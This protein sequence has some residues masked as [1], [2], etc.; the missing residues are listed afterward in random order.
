[1]RGV[2]IDLPLERTLAA[3]VVAAVTFVAARQRH[4][5]RRKGATCRAVPDGRGHQSRTWNREAVEKCC[6]EVFGH[7][8][9]DDQW[10]VVEAVLSGKDTMVVWATGTGKSLCYQLLAVLEPGNIVIVV[11]PTISLM[12][13]QV[14][15]FNNVMRTRRQPFSAC[16]L[17]P[18]EPFAR[19]VGRA[20]TEGKHCLIYVSPEH[21]TGSDLL[22]ALSDLYKKR[23][24]RLFAVD[25]ADRISDWGSDF[26]VAFRDLWFAREKYSPVPTMALSGAA[27]PVVRKDVADVL[28]LRKP[29]HSIGSFYRPNLFLM[30][31]GKSEAGFDD[32]MDSIHS[33]IERAGGQSIV[34]VP[35]IKRCE[36]VASNLASR[37]LKV[38]IYHGDMDN[39]E[40]TAKQRIFDDNTVQVMV[41]TV[42]FGMG[43]NKPNIRCIFQY[44]APKTVEDYVQQ[45]GRAG[46][47]SE[48]AFCYLLADE[49]DFAL[50]RGAFFNKDLKSWPTEVME[51][52]HKSMLTL[53]K[54]A[55]T[56]QCRWK[57]T[58]SH[59][60]DRSLETNCGCC[61]ICVDVSF[62]GADASAEAAL[63]LEAIDITGERPQGRDALLRIAAGSWSPPWESSHHNKMKAAMVHKTMKDLRQRCPKL[64]LVLLKD[65]LESLRLRGYAEHKVMVASTKSFHY[66]VYQLTDKGKAT[67]R[68]KFPIRIPNPSPQ[69]VARLEASRRKT[70]GSTRG[71]AA[72][73][74]RG[75]GGH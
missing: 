24:L 4:A 15:Q 10:K 29:V 61:D 62:D 23:R 6:E 43:I 47:D 33:C 75:Q 45:I 2:S 46:R 7:V 42:A 51:A 65:V 69:L 9:R 66:M 44:G 60:G 70:G 40:R 22:D 41:A 54:L 73:A 34:Y 16:K 49:K 18:S 27:S 39:R 38:S 19:S 52:H 11:S 3:Q 64:T 28:R 58:L 35:T 13:D 55:E 74:A 5:G 67:L 56:R 48:P 32:D 68:W 50:W 25:E 20:A 57:S 26:R 72:A 1:M 36:A 12:A 8:L 59:L 14:N 17:G 63:L 30:C 53:Q 31:S 21:L 37:G 71:D